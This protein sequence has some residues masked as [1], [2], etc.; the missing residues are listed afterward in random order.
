MAGS[1]EIH[2]FQQPDDLTEFAHGRS[3]GVQTSRGAFGR[4][5]FE[6]GWRWSDSVKPIVKTEL[7][8]QDHFL[9]LASG[10]LHVQMGDGAE[11]DLGPGTVAHIPPGHDAWVVGDE[12]VTTVDLFPDISAGYAK[13]SE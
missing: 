4:G 13:P 11:S 3:E 2:S 10:T 1:V 7:C 6:P 9:Y 5:V 8:Q 12:V